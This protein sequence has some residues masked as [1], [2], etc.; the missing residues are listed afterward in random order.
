MKDNKDIKAIIW[1]NWGV[2]V[3]A[4]CGSI[5]KVWAELLE[6]PVEDII[7]VF[8]GPE[9]NQFHSDEIG[10]NDFLNF[11]IQEL[12]LPAEKKEALWYEA[13]DAYAYD[14][15][16]VEYIKLLKN[17]YS[18]AMLSNVS[19][20]TFEKGCFFWPELFGLFDHVIASYDVKLIKPDPRIYKLTLN[21]IGCKAEEAIFIDDTD[22]F[23]QAAQELGIHSILYE[24]R[25]QAIEE[26]E[27][28]LS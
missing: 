12:K 26:L 5:V 20:S 1:D 7:R 22:E 25:E 16:L 27:S 18:V 10:R 24:N 15:E 6:A 23:V 13:L 3:N 11:V 17:T 8:S 2:L 28:I 21:K 14:K 19:R 9:L 4:K